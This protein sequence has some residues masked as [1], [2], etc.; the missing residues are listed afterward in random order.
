[1]TT[2][3]KGCRLIDGNGGVPVENAAI[4]VEEDKIKAVGPE[5]GLEW[6]NE[7]AVIDAQGK[8]LLPGF[9]DVHSHVIAYEYD[10]ET[11]VT[12]PM[13]LTVV[14]TLKNMKKVL[15]SGVTTLR[16]GGGADKGL[17]MAQ[18][19]G[20]VEGPRMFICIVPMSQTGG[21]FDLHLGSGA[22]LDMNQ[23]YGTTRTFVNGVEKPAP[24]LPAAD[25]GRGR[26][27]QG[28]LH[29]DGLPGHPG[30]CPGSP[31]HRGGDG[32]GGLRGQGRGQAHH[33]PLR[34]RPGPDQRP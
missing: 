27:A 1:M 9:I 13:S 5:A 25:R 23:M 21:L 32:R 24:P 33:D 16:D 7:A 22:T 10:L 17:K 11:R 19:Q 4:V 6:S 14:K 28:L 18:A 34:G 29:R 8:T 2:V 12:T 26:C 15:E 20:L 31:V 3:I 30:H